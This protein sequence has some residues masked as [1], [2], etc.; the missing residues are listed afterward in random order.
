MKLKS[1]EVQ[2]YR[3][4][5]KT[6]KLHLDPGLTVILGP[7]NEGKSNLLRAIVLAME[8]L[9]TLRQPGLGSVRWKE[10]RASRRPSRLFDWERDYPLAAQ[11]KTPEGESTF[12][13]EFELSQDEQKLFKAEIGSATNK[14]LPLEIAVGPR[15]TPRFRVR[16][17]GKGTKGYESKSSEIARFV[18]GRFEIQYI[19]AIRPSELSL[20]VVASLVD[21]ELATLTSNPEYQAA[22]KTVEDLQK[23]VLDQ[24]AANVQ[25]YLRQLLPS[26]KAV[27]IG[28]VSVDG[29]RARFRMPQFIVDDGSATELDAKGDGVKSLVAISL[30]RTARA[31]GAAGDLVVAIEE[32]ESHLHPEAIR[33]LAV[34]LREIAKEHQVIITTHS[35]LLVARNRVEAN[36]IVSRSRATPAKNIRTIRQSL[37]VR[38]E[39]NLVSAEYVI[40]VE[41]ESDITILAALFCSLSQ[42]FDQQFR[43]GKVVFDH[44]YGTGN[45]AYK[46]A[47]L[48]LNVATPILV[49]D[50]DK[51][52][53]GCAK[54]AKAEGGLDDKHMFFVKRP[55]APETELE[56]ILNSACY[57]AKARSEFGAQLDRPAFDSAVGKWSTRMQ[58]SFESA[59]KAWSS[60][61]ES[62]LKKTIAECVKANP[63]SALD[64]KGTRLLKSIAEAIASI[65]AGNE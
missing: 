2:N 37:G 55:K 60:S 49:L 48:R 47:T 50:D 63:S 53:R 3:S 57:W 16:K 43:E 30:M 32:P 39:D 56:D 61:V 38:V 52:G 40:L 51:A 42:K 7:N 26:V 29:Y 62:N 20:D 12:A 1:I 41:G 4:I 24:L 44:L 9:R 28:S 5:T 33:Q 35:P 14:N 21:R 64:G 18:S 22:L 25:T 36:I 15:G 19:P 34:V 10:D 13:L 65:V 45:I 17:Q 58:S 54:K 11:Q 6:T 23:P 8:C 31:G 46:I 59:G 27:K